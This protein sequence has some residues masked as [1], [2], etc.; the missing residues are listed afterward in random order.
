[1]TPLMAS[2]VEWVMSYVGRIMS[3]E[4]REPHHEMIGKGPG[5]SLTFRCSRGQSPRLI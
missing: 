1:M 2:S 4:S 3:R 5:V